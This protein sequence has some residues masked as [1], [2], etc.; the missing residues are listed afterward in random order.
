MSCGGLLPSPGCAR[1]CT[2]PSGWCHGSEGLLSS[3]SG[4]L[5]ESGGAQWLDKLPYCT[6]WCVRLHLQVCVC[7]VDVCVWLIKTHNFST[8][9]ALFYKRNVVNHI[10]NDIRG[11]KTG[12][13]S[14]QLCRVMDQS[15]AKTHRQ[16][17]LRLQCTE[18]LCLLSHTHSHS[19]RL[20]NQHPLNN[21]ATFV[22][23]TFFF[24]SFLVW[25]ERLIHLEMNINSV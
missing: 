14:R 22:Q 20:I 21:Y 25:N 19:R 5:S 16:W 4:S 1:T 12:T 3:G 13:Q 10:V 7:R 6:M 24:V 8:K 9:S 2:P 23:R 11:F 17:R 15:S 18:L